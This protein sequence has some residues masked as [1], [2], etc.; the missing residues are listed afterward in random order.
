MKLAEQIR[1][2]INKLPKGK[3]FGYADLGIVKEDYQTGAKALERLQTKG[4]IKKIS[5][6]VFY[7]PEQTVFG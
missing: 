1:I 7:K 2:R 4:V 6:G 5:K 3:T